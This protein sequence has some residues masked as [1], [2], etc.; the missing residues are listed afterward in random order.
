MYLIAAL[1]FS[2]PAFGQSVQQ[3][4]S[5]VQNHVPVWIT[6]G[7]IGDSGTASDS[8]VSTFGVTNNG[9]PGICVSTGR[10][11]ASGRQQ[12]CLSASLA[13]H[14][15]LSL[16]NYGTASSQS[17]D[18]IINGIT[19]P[20]PGSLSQVTIGTT[21]II[22]GTIDNCLYVNTSNLVDNKACSLSSIVALTGDVTATGPGTVPATLATVNNN[23]GTFGS[24]TATASFTVNGKGLVTAASN[25]TIDIPGTQLTG[26]TLASNIVTS[27]LT[28]VG[29]IA[30]GVWHGTILSPTYGGTGINNGSNTL[31]LAANLATTGTS[32]PTFAFPSS[33]AFTYTFQGSSD[34]L[35]GLATTDVLTNKTLTSPTI[36]SGALSGTFSGTPTLS[37]ANFV[38]NANLVQGAAATLKGN[39]TASLA[40][41][42]D[43]TVQ[44]LVDIT[45]PNT[46]LDWVLIYNHST[47]T[48][49]K[50]NVSEMLSVAGAG[51]TSL[52]ALAGTLTIANGNGIA[53]ITAVS[54]T[55]T[56][57]ADL[58]SAGQFEAGT[59]NKV[60]GADV[61]FT[62]ETTT[63]YGTTTTFNF[64]TFINTNVTL[65]G[66]I[67]TATCS[68]IKA[69]Q[70]GTIRFIQDGSGSRTAV[71]CSQFK[72]AAGTA[73]T[74][75]T[76]ASA[77]DALSYACSSTSYCVVSLIKNVS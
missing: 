11:T 44:S 1:S 15:S 30:T 8:P 68:N 23:T 21:P 34:T 71:W 31:T 50:T 38:T 48:L 64:S 10:V 32:T 75:S 20:F 36:N 60:L 53:A 18:F 5:V 70:A 59:A 41:V 25:I 63:T 16:Q 67:T 27:S 28:T 17:L 35:V 77:I 9:G 55:I 58:A 22:G 4:G 2:F 65:T 57:S 33:T 69:G 7:V 3:S 76:A 45:T 72:W 39:A 6:N 19:Y 46:T 13:G 51:V 49:E 24:A 61:V 42:A 56:V 43:F 40:N 29:T 62:S 66:N 73:A 74:L 54:T 37:G 12:L 52:N 14:A 26:T 47:G